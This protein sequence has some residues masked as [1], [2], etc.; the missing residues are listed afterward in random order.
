MAAAKVRHWAAL[1]V[2]LLWTLGPIYWAF[3]TSLQTDVRAQSRP[4][5]YLP[6]PVT[7]DNYAKLLGIGAANAGTEL[8]S[9]IR[10]SALNIFVECSLA[11]LFTVVLA[12]LAGYAFA[13]IRFRLSGTLFYVV[14]ATMALPAYAT[15]IPLYRMLAAVH[16][17]NTY[18]GIVLVYTAGI[19]PLAIWILYNYFHGIPSEV[20]EAAFVDGAGRLRTLWYVILPIARP[21]IMAAAIITF[22]SGYTHFLF[23]LVLTSDISTQPLT[24]VIASL[25]GQHQVPYTLLNAGG[26]LAI[27]APVVVTLLLSRYIISGLLQGSVK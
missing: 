6:F 11:M 13:R 21:G 5:N 9:A 7:W 14:L 23:P 2:C 20:E 15:L 16:L 18:T 4:P 17:V 22:L 19:L 1:T 24:V 12:V 27:L 25:Q 8:S 26:I 10:R 3:N